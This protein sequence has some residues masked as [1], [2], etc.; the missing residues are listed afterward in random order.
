MLLKKIY[1]QQKCIVNPS[2]QWISSSMSIE[3]NQPKSGKTPTSMRLVI[4]LSWLMKIFQYKCLGG[5]M[6]HFPKNPHSAEYL[7]HMLCD[8][9]HRMC[10]IWDLNCPAYCIMAKTIKQQILAITSGSPA[11]K[12]QKIVCT[13]KCRGVC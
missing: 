7:E 3:W 10:P 11:S 1:H 13:G 8:V 4:S 6:P 12:K 9:V 5:W 2:S